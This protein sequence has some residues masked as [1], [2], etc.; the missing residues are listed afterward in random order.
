VLFLRAALLPCAELLGCTPAAQQ[1]PAAAATA[2]DVATAPS[3]VAQVESSGASGATASPLPLWLVRGRAGQR[4]Y[5]LPSVHVATPATYPLDPAIEAAFQSSDELVLEVAPDE[6]AQAAP[7]LAELGVFPVGE[8]LSTRV[9]RD[10]WDA[11]EAQ[12]RGYGIGANAFE[13]FRPWFAALN[14]TLLSVQSAGYSSDLGLDVHFMRAA[15]SRRMPIR[16]LET[17]RSQVDLLAQLD[18]TTQLAFLRESLSEAA[19]APALLEGAFRAWHQGDTATLNTLLLEPM[20]SNEPELFE[21]FVG[22]RNRAMLAAML[23]W[24]DAPAAGAK[25]RFIVVGALHV[26]GE[27]GLLAGFSAHGLEVSRAIRSAGL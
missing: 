14:L 15:Q 3:A 26:I 20:R 27:Q 4:A 11:L 10:V 23:P 21:R 5:V 7:L 13:R 6:V 1:P 22:Q 2:A 24:F 17:A 16:G 18:D 12:V 25:S 19:D 9:P 8:R